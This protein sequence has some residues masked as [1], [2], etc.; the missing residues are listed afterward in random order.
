MKQLLIIGGGL[1]GVTAAKKARSLHSPEELSI[2]IATE[3]KPPC[4]FRPRL[5]EL[6]AGYIREEDMVFPRDSYFQ[7]H[8]ISLIHPV[9]AARI[10]PIEKRVYFTGSSPEESLSYDALILATGSR[11]FAPVI[12]DMY[13]PAAGTVFSLRTMADVQS[14]RQHLAMNRKK[15]AVLGGGL[16]GLELARALKSTGI[17]EVHVLEASGYLLNRQLNRTAS[18]MLRMYLDKQEGLRIH[19]GVQVETKELK[20]RTVEE[21]LRPV[22]GDGVETLLYSMGVRSQFQLAQ[23]AGLTCSKGIVVDETMATSNQDIYAAGDCA[24]FQGLTWGIVP[25][26]L[27]Q[28]EKAAEFACW[29]LFSQEASAK[30]EA[31]S[32]LQNSSDAASGSVKP[33]PAPYRQTVPHTAITIGKRKAVSVGKAVLTAEEENSGNWKNHEILPPGRRGKRV[34]E[35]VYVNF[36][37]HC[38][39]GLIV[40]GLVLGLPQECDLWFSRVRQLEGKSWQQEKERLGANFS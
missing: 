9:H 8:R 16:L 30:R 1:S 14:I 19:T 15:A 6:L 17:E 23:E 34:L 31:P 4:Y 29:N 40:G 35:E 2:T 39:T 37:E 33:K 21:I 25:A 38:T 26:A 32:N 24:E 11:A 3:E 10:D 20:N 7:S 28:G 27:E 18:E 13:S 12:P 5:T 22:C 36:V